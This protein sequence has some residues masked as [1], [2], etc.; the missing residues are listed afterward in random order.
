[1]TKFLD[2]TGL[3]YFWE[4]IKANFFR[5]NRDQTLDMNDI[6]TPGIYTGDFAASSCPWTNHTDGTGTEK[7]HL[8]VTEYSD[9]NVFVKNVVSQI[10]IC[11]KFLKISLIYHRAS[12]TKHNLEDDTYEFAWGD[13][14][15]ILTQ[16][17]LDELAGE[18]IP[19]IYGDEPTI[20]DK[21]EEI[22]DKLDTDGFH[23]YGVIKISGTDSSIGTWMKSNFI[24]NKWCRVKVFP[25]DSS[26]YYGSSSVS[27]MYNLSSGNYG[28]A[29]CTSDNITKEPMRVG[30]L[31]GG[32][33][34]FTQM[35]YAYQLTTIG[36]KRNVATTPNDYRNKLVFQG[37]KLNSSIGNPTTAV[38][39]SYVVGLCGWS[40]RS[41]GGAWEIAFNDKGIFIRRE[42]ATKNTWASWVALYSG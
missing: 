29:I 31:Y 20:K 42:G 9:A 18:D 17:D 24:Y 11:N 35:P 30:Q 10:A 6:R 37:L 13:W 12:Y 19:Y 14:H 38:V 40:D 7:Y 22:K 16:R 36:D 28:T 27:I 3:S 34:T 15:R 41:G 23:D 39:Y 26:G 1:M 32:N 4:K 33:W 2:N 5:Y 8:I 25:T 21:I